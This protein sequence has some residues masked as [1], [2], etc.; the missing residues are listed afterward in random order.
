MN[1]DI[2][3]SGDASLCRFPHTAKADYFAVIKPGWNGY[4]DFFLT[5]H[6][7]SPPAG[8]AFFFRCFA[9][10]AAHS[11]YS[12]IRKGAEDGIA[13]FADFPVAVANFT[14][15]KLGSLFCSAAVTGLAYRKF[16]NQNFTLDP[17]H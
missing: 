7:T 8:R 15:N 2:E 5:T 13:G 14:G 17:E 6:N 4:R 3:V 1:F 12:Y 10:A 9:G 16:C 11:A